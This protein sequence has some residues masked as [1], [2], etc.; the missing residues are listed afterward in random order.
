MD[1]AV[2]VEV[3]AQALR[4]FRPSVY[5]IGRVEDRT[6]TLTVDASAAGRLNAAAR[7]VTALT[8]GGIGVVA[9]DPIDALAAAP[10]S[11]WRSGTGNRH[12]Q[13]TWRR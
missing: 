8:D 6:N 1:T 9:D 13:V 3:A 11:C 10:A 2:S 4:R 5:R 12:G 7:I